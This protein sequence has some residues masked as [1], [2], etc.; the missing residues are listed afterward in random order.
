MTNNL[1]PN[2]QVQDTRGNV[3]QVLME[4]HIREQGAYDD[5]ERKRMK[6]INK[7]TLA[8]RLSIFATIP[9]SLKNSRVIEHGHGRAQ[10]GWAP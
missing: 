5:I 1:I 9:V 4:G 8:E 3:E 10:D 6:Y 7:L 2:Q